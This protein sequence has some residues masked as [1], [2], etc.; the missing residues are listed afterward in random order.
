MTDLNEMMDIARNAKAWPFAEATMLAKRL[1][2]MGGP[3]K[4]SVIFETGYGPS[5]LPHIGT[6][7]EVV[8]T[9]IV[10][11]AFETLTG[12]KTRLICFSDD[13]DG[14]RKIPDNI[15]NPE[16]L[17]PYLHMHYRLP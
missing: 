16:Q 17:E 3:E 2:K 15:P 10:R 4:D 12:A 13:L 5:G 14:F 11:H 9:S 6:F 1:D 8:R 7:G